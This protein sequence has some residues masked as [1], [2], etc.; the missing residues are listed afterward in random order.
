[1]S[2]TP[3]GPITPQTSGYQNTATTAVSE[4]DKEFEAIAQQKIRT[5]VDGNGVKGED[6]QFLHFEGVTLQF[7]ATTKLQFK[8]KTLERVE[9]GKKG[10][11]ITLLSGPQQIRDEIA[12]QEQRITH[13]GDLIKR[14]QTHLVE[15]R[16]DMGYGLDGQMVKLPFL[17]TDYVCH[18]PCN[19]CRT[20]GNV[21]C[22]RCNGQGY[23][24]CTKCHGQ[25]LE[26]CTLCH[27]NKFVMGP[28]GR[29]Q[30]TKCHGRGKCSCSLCHERMKIQCRICKT[31]GSTT[32]TVCNGHAWNSRIYTLEIDAMPSFWYDK[33]NVQ[34]RVG[35]VIQEMGSKL[36]EHAKIQAILKTEDDKEHEDKRDFVEIPYIVQLPYAELRYSINS[37]IYNTMIFGNQH[38]LKYVP[39]IIDKLIKSPLTRLQEAA[40]NRGNVAEKVQNAA[41]YRALRLA[42]LAAARMPL[43][44]AAKKVK[45]EYPHG[46]QNDTI[47]TMVTCA[48][49]A[50]KNITRRPRQIGFIAGL[51]L[52][53]LLYGL[54]FY[55]GIR[56][57]VVAALQDPV[58]HLV[59]DFCIFLAGLG[60]GILAIKLVGKKA[61]VDALKG[62]IPA[63]KEKS[64]MPKTG[65][66]GYRLIALA[67]FLFILILETGVHIPAL[68]SFQPDWFT[69]IRSNILLATG[70][71]APTPSP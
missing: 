70:L 60:T 47:K 43:A 1:M 54:Y 45:H 38:E 22:Q 21:M 3:A 12:K 7:L 34:E 39:Y 5:L 66:A 14:V 61:L 16:K 29:Q 8:F 71:A 35:D 57:P 56:P 68:A 10:G 48:D 20:K 18:E 52:M 51:L 9:M 19:T 41:Q 27:G 2:D 58:H 13:R 50:L 62:I 28:K 63:G 11:N 33:D 36:V 69:H 40:E 6:V 42:I 67:P 31:K 17:Y 46:L 25:G 49:Q 26:L 53:P 23:E 15:S 44:K 32:C 59:A 4:I 37:Q 64:F 65:K 30:C 24:K 55:G